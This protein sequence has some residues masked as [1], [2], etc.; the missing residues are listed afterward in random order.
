MNIDDIKRRAKLLAA[1]DE[2]ERRGPAY[3]NTM[4]WLCYLGL[5]RHNQ[6]PPRRVEVTLDDMLQAA[7][8][9]P[10]ILELLPALLI[11][12]PD[13]LAGV[14]EADLPADLAGV[15]E[16]IRRRD[17]RDAFRNACSADGAAEELERI[18][19]EPVIVLRDAGHGFGIAQHAAL[20]V[21][22]PPG[23]VAHVAAVLRGR[24]GGRRGTI[25]GGDDAHAGV[26]DA[27][28]AGG[29]LAA[30]GER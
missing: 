28:R 18:G 25:R 30:Q 3:V 12:L 23:E 7:R 13:A 26:G 2:G 1:K 19:D 16:Q 20:Q 22:Q 6:V 14:T 17:A 10:R 11:A 9:E 15:V 8:L 24:G 29:A 5:L 27:R 21:T 4:A